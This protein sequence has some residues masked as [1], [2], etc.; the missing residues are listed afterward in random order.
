MNRIFTYCLH[1][2]LLIFIYLHIS[3]LNAQEI[4]GIEILPENPGNTDEIRLVVHT[5]FPY[6]D[7]RLDSI[8]PY[9]ACGAFS[10]DAFYNTGFEMDSCESSDTVSLG[11]LNNGMYIISY[12]MYFLGWS[13]VDQ[14]D[15]FIVVGTTGL[16]HLS[17]TENGL[18]IWP[19]PSHGNLNI[20]T[21]GLEADLLRIVNTADG[22]T[23]KITLD[24]NVPI[25]QNEVSLKPG[26]YI[27]TA[28]RNN[29]AV[30]VTKFIVFE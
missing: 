30:A 3:L 24:S 10:Y 28:F 4:T 12:R 16:E 2:G 8:N 14:A 11:V 18:R 27:C 22:H 21:S 15:T 5:A 7:C 29:A 13:Q 23:K 1:A 26:F 20:Q 9:F 19:N 25:Q 17:G 6:S